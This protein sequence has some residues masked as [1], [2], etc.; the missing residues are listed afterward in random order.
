MS[1]P[2]QEEWI[3]DMRERQ[4]NVVFPDALRNEASGWRRL[5]T[6]KQ[7]LTTVHAVGIGLLFLAMGVV[8]GGLI[9]EKLRRSAGD[10]FIDR[11]FGG[12]GDWIVLFAIL[13]TFFLLLR[14]RV[15]RALRANKRQ[16]STGE[17]NLN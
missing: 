4:R 8:L 6:S 3:K 14:W 16:S 13:G 17:Q 10:S 12:F 9:S 1:K 5:M 15:R 7:P 11:V 2:G